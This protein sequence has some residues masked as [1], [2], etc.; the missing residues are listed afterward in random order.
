MGSYMAHFSVKH[1]SVLYS[2]PLGTYKPGKKHCSTC[3]SHTNRYYYGH[4]TAQCSRNLT[5]PPTPPTQALSAVTTQSTLDK[6]APISL[7][8]NLGYNFEP[9]HYLPNPQANVAQTQSHLLTPLQALEFLHSQ[10]IF[11]ENNSPNNN[12]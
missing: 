7:L 9:P 4:T 11:I 1:Y 6:D 10:G 2:Q 3:F 8:H 12:K 5:S